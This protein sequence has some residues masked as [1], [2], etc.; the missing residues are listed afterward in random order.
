[1]TSQEMYPELYTFRF[2]LKQSLKML[3]RHPGISSVADLFSNYG[4]W[5]AAGYEGIFNDP[6]PWMADAAVRFISASCKPSGRVFEFGSGASTL[7]FSTRVSEVC[8]V[9]HNPDWFRDMEQ[10]TGRRGIKNVT[11]RLMAGQPKED[12]REAGAPDDPLQYSSVFE[13]YKK[14][15]FYGYASSIDA[16]PEEYFDMIV[17]D[18]RAR[19]SCMLHAWP[20]LRKGG[21][22]VLDNS[23]RPHYQASV[24]ETDRLAVKKWKFYGPVAQNPMFQE[25]SFWMK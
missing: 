12:G 7:F 20:R 17:V 23:D 4:K 10:E 13:A 21:L 9:E 24:A 8:S 3:L 25:T 16:W 2:Y 14:V 15:S 1:M 19:P 22:L 6:K 18:G 5:K 11:L